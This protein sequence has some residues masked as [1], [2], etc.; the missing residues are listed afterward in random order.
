MNKNK[1][2]NKTYKT[3]YEVDP[4]FWLN[5]D[6]SGSSNREISCQ[7]ST[8]VSFAPGALEVL[9]MSWLSNS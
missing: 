1:E 7:F 3:I 8:A 2:K 4:L 5:I 9:V 6:P